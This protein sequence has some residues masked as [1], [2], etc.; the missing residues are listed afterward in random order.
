MPA[1]SIAKKKA[2][3]ERAFRRAGVQFKFESFEGKPEDYKRLMGYTKNP[4]GG[5]PTVIVHV[6]WLGLLSAADLYDFVTHEIAHVRD[7]KKGLNPRRH[8]SAEVA[9]DSE[10]VGILADVRRDITDLR[11]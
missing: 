3:A 5:E 8:L 1:W 4:F 6:E 11:L 7:A 2:L 9:H 10:F